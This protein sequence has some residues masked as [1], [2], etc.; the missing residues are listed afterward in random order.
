[1]LEEIRLGLRYVRENPMIRSAL[2]MTAVMSI[3]V[4][5]YPSQMPAFAREVLG[6]GPQGLGM[7]VSGAG[8]GAL[9]AA[10]S[11]AALG[12]LFRQET[13]MMAGS[14]I[15]P[16]GIIML[17]CTQSLPVSVGCLVVVGF[18]AM[19]FLAVSNSL[20][21]MKSPDNMRGRI[22]SLRTVVF[23]GLAPI[24]ALL[25]GVMAQYLGVQPALRYGAF[26]SAAAAAYFALKP[27]ISEESE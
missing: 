6:A 12:H 8:V 15:T 27:G 25:V 5:Q 18:G 10:L 23:M 21:Q 7:L 14:L 2:L 4:M 3:F 13:M 20:V 9:L 24:G 11:V 22:V 17:G 16:A 1:V 26:V 19:L